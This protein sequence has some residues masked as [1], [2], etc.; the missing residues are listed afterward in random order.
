MVT[1]SGAV[2]GLLTT[3]GHR[4]EIELRRGFKEDV[5][6]PAQAPPFPIC[7]RRRRIGI[8]ER[9]DFQGNVVIPLDEAAVR[10]GIQ[11]L[12]R[13][14][15][16]SLAVV[17]LFS[18]VNSAHEKRAAEIVR[19]EWPEVTLSLSHEVMP[20][21][22]RVR[23]HL[24]D[25]RRCLRHSK[26]PPLRR[27]SRRALARGRLP[28]SAVV[29]QSN[30]GAM[31]CE[32]VCR[33]AVAVLGSGPTGGVMGA[34]HVG[35]LVGVEDFVA[36][37]M[38]GTSYDVCLVRAGAPQMQLGVA[39]APPLCRRCRRGRRGVDRRRQRLDRRSRDGCAEGRSA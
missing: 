36:A 24:D 18:F 29:M 4:D 9:L 5:W 13:Q 27:T 35:S 30:G 22:R 21:G 26:R 16:E 20:C 25:A 8:P 32:Y 28:R 14:G 17:F 23:A 39:L 6:N 15:V 37:D 33:R 1:R 38:G 10:A 7:P 3:Q 2:T 34:R 12:K 19:E 11:R 31:T